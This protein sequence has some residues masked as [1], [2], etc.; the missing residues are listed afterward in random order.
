M[1]NFE[2]YRR[3]WILPEIGLNGQEKLSKAHVL[4]IGAGGLGC[5]VLQYLTAAG[6]GKLVI[7]DFDK[8]DLT[9]LQRQVLYSV[10][11]I[12][13]AKSIV[14]ADKLR[15][16]NPEIDI[17][18]VTA[19][20]DE[21][22]ADALV[23]CADLVID[24]SDNFTT[25][26]LLNSCCEKFEKP[27]VYGSIHRFEGQV[28]VFHY[29]GSP[30]LEALYPEPPEEM[31]NQT[32]SE[33]GVVGA[34]PGLVGSVQ[35]LEAIKIITGAGE[36]MAGKLWVWNTLT[37][38]PQVFT[39]WEPEKSP[40]SN[41][42][43]IEKQITKETLPELKATYPNLRI[44]DLREPYEFEAFNIG[45]ESIPLL[46]FTECNWSESCPV[47]LVCS[48]GLRSKTALNWIMSNYPQVKAFHLSEG[49][50]EQ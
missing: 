24:G 19:K 37:M 1:T 20:L 40:Q 44:I 17:E 47:L 38:H 42:S 43:G 9:N 23:L 6:V 5:P 30:G 26:Y 15:K 13:K 49:I 36:S 32:C 31:E 10:E 41:F 33:I 3:Q 2:R 18:A 8:V 22:N 21:Y 34:L 46:D 50:G 25:R 45:G 14:A 28:S 16:L 35:A 4:V 7:V 11:D 29:H 27:L 12:G 39:Y 48:T